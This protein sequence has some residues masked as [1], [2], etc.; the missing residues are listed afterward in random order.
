MEVASTVP[1][2]A[3]AEKFVTSMEAPA[4]TVVNGSSGNNR[5]RT[6]RTTALCGQDSI[7]LGFSQ[8]ELETL[9]S[10]PCL[11]LLLNASHPQPFVTKVVSTLDI[12]NR[13]HEDSDCLV[14]VRRCGSCD[15]CR[16]RPSA[17][18]QQ[19]QS[20]LNLVGH[21]SETYLKGNAIIIRHIRNNFFVG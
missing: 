20:A 10:T 17:P 13:N 14:V 1:D 12:L 2:E 16:S 3:P 21:G 6:S 4:P 5:K 8:G 11:R 15:V 18:K 9:R 7:Y 19:A